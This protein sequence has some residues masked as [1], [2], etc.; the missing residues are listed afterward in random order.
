MSELYLVDDLFNTLIALEEYGM[1]TYRELAEKVNDMEVN[2]IFLS[3]AN[4]EE[5]HKDYYSELRLKFE[6]SEE[7]D[8][9][10]RSFLQVLI[11]NSFFKTEVLKETYDVQSALNLGI[12]LEKETLLFLSEIQVVL[13]EKSHKVFEDVK[14]EERRHLAMLLAIVESRKE[15]K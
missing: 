9:E 14:N 15:K 4:Q 3:L 7:V 1:K 5:E 6:S 11:K 2:K 8:D 13:G 10:Y 12:K